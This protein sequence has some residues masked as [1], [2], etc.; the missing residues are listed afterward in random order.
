MDTWC[1]FH[2]QLGAKLKVKSLVQSVSPTKQW[3]TLPVNTIRI[4]HQLLCLTLYAICQQ[5]QRKSTRTK[6][7]CRLLIKL[8]P[9]VNFINKQLLCQYSFAKK[10]QSQTVI[11]EKLHKALL[12]KNMRVKCWWNWLLDCN[13]RGALKTIS[14]S[15]ETEEAR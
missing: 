4:Y 3:P 7:D 11:R 13:V 2:Q 10:L 15:I 1:Q 8:T 9:L 12:Y 14:L 5:D 6:A